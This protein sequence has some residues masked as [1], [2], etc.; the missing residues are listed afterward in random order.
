[1]D[2]EHHFLPGL[3]C[4]LSRIAA[5]AHLVQHVHTYDH[6]S[7]LVKGSASV[8]MDSGVTWTLY[9]AP[10]TLLIRAGIAH[11]VMALTDIE[12][13]CAHISDET[14][15]EK[16]D[17]TLIERNHDALGCCGTMDRV[18]AL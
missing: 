10:A 6:A 15:P 4:K 7:H 1:M 17:E 3:Y 14:D 5:G 18:G 8:S 9:Q 11:E 2:I 13:Y 16:I 12:W